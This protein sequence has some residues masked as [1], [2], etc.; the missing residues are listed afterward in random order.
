M[1]YKNSYSRIEIEEVTKEYIFKGGV[2]VKKYKPI[3]N[4]YNIFK[5]DLTIKKLN[6]IIIDIVKNIDTKTQLNYFIKN[7]AIYII[8]Y[9]NGYNYALDSNTINNFMD[10]ENEINVI[11]KEIKIKINNNKNIKFKS[12]KNK[13]NSSD[14]NRF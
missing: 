12:L 3:N 13:F 10:G 7:N 5:K 6:N 14:L 2:I 1:K 11:I 4:N 8:D 9:S